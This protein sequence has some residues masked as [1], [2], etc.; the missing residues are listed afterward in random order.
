VSSL[1]G[2]VLDVACSA[3]RDYLP[4]TATMIASL[5]ANAGLGLR[6]HLLLG[7]DVSEPEAEAV[8]R[9]AADRG[10]EL[11]VHRIGDARLEQLK[12]TTTLPTAHWYRVLLPEL[13]P[14]VGRALYLDGD[15]IV[16]EP[17]AELAGLDLGGCRLAAVTNPFPDNESAARLCAGLG[18]E[19]ERYFNSGVMLL[20]LEALRADDAP[21]RVIAYAAENAERL[22]LPEQD[23]M[24][25]VL[26]AQR[27]PLAPRWNSMIGV[28]RLAWSERLF[29]AEAVREARERPA[30]RH[31]EGSDANKPWHP[32]AEPEHRR[33]YESYRR[34]TPWPEIEPQP[35]TR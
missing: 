19:P 20:D 13:L 33:L 29:G 10:A 15:T 32:G 34:L 21:A 17:L 11:V 25:A 9:M 24:N 1:A 26:A 2:D 6:V 35:E 16:V 23:A 27:L 3:R 14:E 18:V 12:T 5:T 8:A 31:F 28:D 30:I 7:A 4:H 22:F